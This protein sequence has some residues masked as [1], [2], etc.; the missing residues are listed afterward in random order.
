MTESKYLKREF[1]EPL[2]TFKGVMKQHQINKL[3]EGWWDNMSDKAKSAYIKKLGSAPGS[4]GGD[5]EPKTDIFGNVPEDPDVDPYGDDDDDWETHGVGPSFW[6]SPT[7]GNEPDDDAQQKGMD[8]A[9]DLAKKGME[10]GEAAAQIKKL[11]QQIKDLDDAKWKAVDSGDHAA[12]ANWGDKLQKAKK[13]REDLSNKIADDKPEGGDL[14][15]QIS[16]AQKDAD[17]ANQMAQQFGGMTQGGDS[18]YDDAAAEA[19]KKLRDLEKQKSAAR[20]GK[21]L[22]QETITVDGKQFRRINE[23]VE[24]KQ[25][26]KYEFSEFYERF[27]K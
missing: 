8:K 21:E 3:E 9:S 5:E 15:S 11:D 14:D 6:D 25:K 7:P 13:E 26:P 4:A 22:N 23:S 19:N 2:P 20:T 12:V 17:N 16:Q 10:K 1:G 18:R 24:N 27:K